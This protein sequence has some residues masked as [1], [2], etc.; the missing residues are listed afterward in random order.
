MVVTLRKKESEEIERIK[1][2]NFHL[3]SVLF[4]KFVFWIL[5][6]KRM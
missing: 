4:F 2:K 3:L 6:V 5:F 1:K